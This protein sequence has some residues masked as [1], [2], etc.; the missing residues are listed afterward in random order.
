MVKVARNFDSFKILVMSLGMSMK[1][2]LVPMFLLLFLAVNFGTLFFY[3]EKDLNSTVTSIPDSIWW[4]IVTIA[5]VGYGDFYPITTEGRFIACIL[6]FVSILF[7]AMPLSIVGTNYINIWLDRHKQG[8]IERIQLTLFMLKWNKDDA[9]RAFQLFDQNGNGFLQLSEFSQMCRDMRVHMNVDDTIELFQA[10]DSDG[11]G[12][13][14]YSTFARALFPDRIWTEAELM[15]ERT[16]QDTEDA[17]E[18]SEEG[19]KQLVI[20]MTNERMSDFKQKMSS[21]NFGRLIN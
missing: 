10:L 16:L 17:K 12:A 11:E 13:L 1:A 21:L 14:R 20:T 5:T 15:T 7:M 19:V 2:L 4:A 18:I 8:L 6:I 9:K 3:F